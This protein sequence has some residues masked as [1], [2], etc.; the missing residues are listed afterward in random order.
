ML[1]GIEAK[2]NRVDEAKKAFSIIEHN[3]EVEILEVLT[4][5]KIETYKDNRL[6]STN[7]AL[8]IKVILG[9]ITGSAAFYILFKL[10]TINALVDNVSETYLAAFIF[11]G[12]ISG[13]LCALLIHYIK[14]ESKPPISI[15]DIEDHEA[16]VVI[17][18]TKDKLD[19][20]L[21]LLKN[22]EVDSIHTT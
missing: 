20:V 15:N 18:V 5:D 10:I 9:L 4:V 11:A 1:I 8:G 16:L 13:L 3:V 17:K 14:K 19:N 12:A 6:D 7:K 21:N 22:T 2:F